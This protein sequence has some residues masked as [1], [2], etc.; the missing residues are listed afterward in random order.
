[1]RWM[2]IAMMV[3]ACGGGKK[4]NPD[5]KVTGD[6]GVD[7][8]SGSNNCPEARVVPGIETPHFD[9]VLA[10]R[11]RAIE[12]APNLVP[13]TMCNVLAQTGCNAGQ[14]CTWIID[15][16]GPPQLGHIGCTPDGIVA[17]RAA[18]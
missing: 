11:V 18:C 5:A 7:T 4:T 6:V 9:R 17:L 8:P 3:A 13:A 16:S 15:S 1:M 2:M 14:K 10:R 12:L